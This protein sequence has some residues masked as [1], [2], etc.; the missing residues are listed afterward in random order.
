[1]NALPLPT[2]LPLPLLGA[3]LAPVALFA[4]RPDQITAIDAVF[5]DVASDST[6]GC[7]LGIMR[8]GRL[9]FGR[10]Y[11]TANLEYRLPITSR[12]VFRTGSV[13]KQITAAAV[14]L[15]AEDRLMDLD[16]PVQA[17][18]K[19][20]PAYFPAP[21]VRQL[22][23]H[24]SGV[25]DYLTLMTLA[26][27]RESDWY[28]DDDVLA[29]LARQTELNFPPGREYLYSNSGYFL[30]AEIVKRVS[31]RNLREFAA[32]RIFAPLGMTVTHFHNDHTEIVP[33]RATG[34]SRTENGRW[35]I[36]M[37]T[38]DMI[39][40]GGVFTTVEDW[41][42]WDANFL[43]PVV[44]GD[45]LV[46]TLL[47]RGVLTSGD[48]IDY[49]FGLRHGSYH[50]LPTIG[51]GGAFVGYRADYVQFPT[52]RTS[53]VALCNFAESEPGRRTR[54]VADVLLEDALAPV[55]ATPAPPGPEAAAR[56]ERRAPGG[57]VRYAGTYYSVELDSRYEIAMRN[58]SLILTLRPGGSSLLQEAEP[59]VLVAGFPGGGAEVRLR[60]E[61]RGGAVAGFQLDAG[62]VKNL[63]FVRE[64]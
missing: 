10:G 6:P 9:T 58:D 22:I 25:R 20:F 12:T 8:D 4:Q 23:H 36:D 62:R 29:M 49:A 21:T 35:R 33:H 1:M 57:G 64:R 2:R 40:D 44:G 13:S 14:A 28:T 61:W 52:H 63:R 32:A 43:R 26:G 55:A 45:A 39:G 11:G 31:G 17:Y 46:P 50:G 42:R 18:L 3:L 47:S 56:P 27:R 54:A 53:I 15:L 51:H 7:A 34:Y 48:T 38:L 37:T 30:L 19:E 60:F 59:D 24:T 41:A 16:T 5:A